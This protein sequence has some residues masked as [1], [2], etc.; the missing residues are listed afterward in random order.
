[1]NISYSPAFLAREFTSLIFLPFLSHHFTPPLL[2]SRLPFPPLN[3]LL[4]D[5][6]A[7]RVCV[8]FGRQRR[9]ERRHLGPFRAR[10][11][12]LHARGVVMG[13]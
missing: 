9:P 3:L 7:A 11:H 10:A 8:R 1:M 13:R 4:V 2:L 6:V 12:Q 5:E